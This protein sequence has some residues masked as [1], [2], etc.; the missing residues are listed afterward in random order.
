MFCGN[1]FFWHHFREDV[2]RK[3]DK[4]MGSN[5]STLTCFTRDRDTDGYYYKAKFSE[6]GKIGEGGCREAYR[7]RYVESS[8]PGGPKVGTQC[9]VKFIK[10]KY[11]RYFEEWDPDVITHRRAKKMADMF[12]SVP[13]S[14]SRTVQVFIPAIA[15]IQRRGGFYLLFLFNVAPMGKEHKYVSIEPY[16]SGDYKKFNDNKGGTDKHSPLLQAFS[17]WTFYK[18]AYK[19]LLCDLQGVQRGNEYLITDP[20]IHSEKRIHGP[21]DLGDVGMLK[22]LRG[23]KC[24]SICK[25]IALPNN[26]VEYKPSTSSGSMY[27]FQLTEEEVRQNVEM[28]VSIINRMREQRIEEKKLKHVKE[29]EQRLEEEKIN[30]VKEFEEVTPSKSHRPL[31]LDIGIATAGFVL[32]VVLHLGLNILSNGRRRDRP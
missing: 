20:C 15:E 19:Y 25:E 24:N 29:Q 14:D 32:P 11:V 1:V 28:D 17:H 10:K 30:D 8:P 13:K 7:G 21:T 16:L 9:V 4:A 18:S 6:D 3:K 2:D 31:P 27:S 12:N 26:T 23:H 5:L 22:F